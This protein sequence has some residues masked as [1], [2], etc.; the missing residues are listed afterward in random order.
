MKY[1]PETERKKVDEGLE[2][3]QKM[4][5][6]VNR[7]R[8]SLWE[9]FNDRDSKQYINHLR[10]ARAYFDYIRQLPKNQIIDL[11]TGTGRAID[12]LSKCSIGNGL[13]FKG[14][15]VKTP[16]QAKGLIDQKNFLET[17][18][19][20]LHGI[21]DESCG[22]ALSVLGSLSYT[23]SIPLSIV[24]IDRVLTPGGVLKAALSVGLGHSRWPYSKRNQEN[25]QDCD[26]APVRRFAALP[27]PH[28]LK[29]QPGHRTQVHAG[30]ACA[31]G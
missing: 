25:Q 2:K 11:G 4:I 27:A 26:D 9:I 16:K 31:Q 30:A 13:N 10:G 23:N 8:G 21:D 14:I 12:G 24:A 1:N 20:Y 28:G 3:L 19:E 5:K 15:D 29:Y 6:R 17:P 7:F 22:G 18:A